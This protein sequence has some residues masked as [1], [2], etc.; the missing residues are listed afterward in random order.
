MK[1]NIAAPAG[2]TAGALLTIVRLA[3]EGRLTKGDLVSTDMLGECEVVGIA[4]LDALRVRQRNTGV[5]V[6]ISG[7]DF[8]PGTVLQTVDPRASLARA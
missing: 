5:I 6:R 4:D 7:I 2:N 3:Q 1:T 8:P